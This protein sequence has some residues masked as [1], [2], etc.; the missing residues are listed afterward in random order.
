MKHHQR[1]LELPKVAAWNIEP[2]PAVAESYAGLRPAAPLSQRVHS[3]SGPL[4]HYKESQRWSIWLRPLWLW[5]SCKHSKALSAVPLLARCG[6]HA[7]WR[8]NLGQHTQL[9]HTG[10]TVRFGAG[11][12]HAPRSRASACATGCVRVGGQA[13]EFQRPQRR[14]HLHNAAHTNSSVVLLPHHTVVTAPQT[15]RPRRVVCAAAAAHN[16]NKRQTPEPARR[17]HHPSHHQYH[18]W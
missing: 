14:T 7:R 2:R 18:R 8:Q 16:N 6:T 3:T 17:R 4:L 13:P 11:A 5:Q 12:L 15:W 10:C 9:L 1:S